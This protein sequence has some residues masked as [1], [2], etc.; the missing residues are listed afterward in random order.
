MGC[1]GCC[2]GCHG[3]GLKGG[4]FEGGDC[5]GGGRDA[6][7]ECISQVA[8][9]SREC[10]GEGSGEVVHHGGAIGRAGVSAGSLQDSDVCGVSERSGFH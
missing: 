2:V 6:L 4:F 5:L 7:G 10:I 3:S 8:V 1:V 9:P